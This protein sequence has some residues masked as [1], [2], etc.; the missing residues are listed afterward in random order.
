MSNSKN[1]LCYLCNKEITEIPDNHHPDKDNKPR[2][3]VPVHH[4]CHMIH[5]GL[6]PKNYSKLR[7]LVDARNVY[8][9]SR[10]RYQH[11]IKALKKLG[12][13]PN[14]IDKKILEYMK[15]R[16]YQLTKEI[17]KI[18]NNLPIW[19]EWLSKVYGIGQLL[20]GQIIAYI[21]DIKRFDSVPKLCSYFGY[22][23]YDNKIQSYEKEH[24]HNYGSEKKAVLYK[25]ASAFISCKSRGSRYGQLYDKYKQIYSEKHPD[26]TESH[27]YLMSLRK[28]C[29]IFLKHLW[30]NWR[31][32]EYEY[33]DE[34]DCDYRV[35]KTGIGLSPSSNTFASRSRIKC[36][37]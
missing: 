12:F 9:L 16:E 4:K 32:I 34:G 6:Y 24:N 33:M 19:K 20:A 3:T 15:K 28:M 25:I 2:Y 18:V 36:H 31:K 29:V 35:E 11:R 30:K 10:I 8:Q 1:L 5:H 17:I 14:E 13:K 21:G 26:Y 7:Q 37:T 22:G 23:L 27:I